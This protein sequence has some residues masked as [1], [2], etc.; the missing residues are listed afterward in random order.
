MV[1]S[2]HV[3]RR[4]FSAGAVVAAAVLLNMLFV[5]LGHLV[6]HPLILDSAFTG[7]AAA[8]CGPLAGT[9]AGLL[10]TLA[11]HATAACRV[12]RTALFA[13][14]G[15]VGLI[16]GLTLQWNAE[17]TPGRIVLALALVVIASSAGTALIMDGL[18]GL[19]GSGGISLIRATY[20]ILGAEPPWP[21]LFYLLPL[22]LADKMLTVGAAVLFGPL[23]G[24]YRERWIGGPTRSPA[25]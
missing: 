12:C 25:A 18:P 20:R 16:A 7:I 4:A 10:S 8:A 13:M 23:L 24:S 6:G 3:R 21:E 19:E 1:R 11:V 14:N 17:V 22:N 2:V 9:V 15:L 5:R